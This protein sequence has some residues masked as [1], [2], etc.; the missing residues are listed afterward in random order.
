[1]RGCPIRTQGIIKRAA[2]RVPSPEVSIPSRTPRGADGAGGAPA[3]M[4]TASSAQSGRQWPSVLLPGRPIPDPNSRSHD[5]RPRW[6]A[7]ASAPS[8]PPSEFGRAGVVACPTPFAPLADLLCP[9]LAARRLTVGLR[10]SF[11]RLT[12]RANLSAFAKFGYAVAYS[13]GQLLT[14]VRLS[15]AA[16]GSTNYG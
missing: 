10:Q 11:Y 15:Q 5:S 3:E 14:R 7:S 6:L 4:H 1:M 9:G 2:P 8:I 13:D 16:V 12:D